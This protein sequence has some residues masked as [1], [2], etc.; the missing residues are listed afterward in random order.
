MVEDAC[1]RAQDALSEL[2]GDDIG[3]GIWM[4]VQFRSRGRMTPEQKDMARRVLEGL[5]PVNF[6]ESMESRPMD[7]EI[8]FFAPHRNPS[9]PSSTLQLVDEQI[10]SEMDAMSDGVL[11]GGDELF[12]EGVWAATP[13]RV[14]NETGPSR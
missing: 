5:G 1:N 8:I 13:S 7:D 10:K 12:F 14:R 4:E 11:P 6:D 9:I 3:S 2:C